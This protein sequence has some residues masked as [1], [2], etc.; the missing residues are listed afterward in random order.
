MLNGK[1]RFM[2]MRIQSEKIAIFLLALLATGIFSYISYA[3]LLNHSRNE[4]HGLLIMTSAFMTAYSDDRGESTVVPATH[5]RRA[6]DYFTKESQESETSSRIT[7]KMPGLPDFE[8]NTV[9]E[10][11]EVRD[12]ISEL[13]LVRDRTFKEETHLSNQRLVDRTIYPSI[14]NSQSC[15]D[16]HNTISDA[17]EWKVGDVMGAFVVESDLTRQTISIAIKSLGVFIFT[18]LILRFI[19][20]R[21]QLQMTQTVLALEAEIIAQKNLQKAERKAKIL[22]SSDALTGLA[23]RTHFRKYAERLLKNEHMIVAFMVDLDY[24]KAINDKHGHQVGDQLLIAISDR[25][26][27]IFQ[28][29]GGL[30]SR[31]GGDEFAAVLPCSNSSSL[32]ADF[33][34][35]VLNELTLPVELDSMQITPSISIG[36]CEGGASFAQLSQYDDILRAADVALY[37]AKENGRNNSVVY[38][39]ELGLIARNAIEIDEAIPKALING[40]FELYF[41]PQVRMAGNHLHGFEALV[42]WRR[43]GEMVM[44]DDFIPIIEKSGRICDVDHF[45]LAQ[46]TKIAARWNRE[47]HNEISVSVNLSPLHFK[48][49]EIVTYVE[50]A[51]VRS[52]LSPHLLTL[53]ITENVVMDSIDQVA[54][55]IRELKSLGVRLSLDDFGTGYSSLS[56]LLS[57][58]VDEVKLDR[59]FL[60]LKENQGVDYGAIDGIC[61]MVRSMGRQLVVEGIETKTTS[62]VI[63]NIGAEYGQGYYFAPPLS[64]ADVDSYIGSFT[65]D[66]PKDIGRAV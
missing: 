10:D 57:L 24:F 52:N 8:I 20:R 46:A 29:A 23:N 48:S 40:E 32:L 63:M 3:S 66:V 9:A 38:T 13:Q 22:A 64:E 31:I 43:N 26:A 35:L 60:M 54:E 39:E 5:R 34:D 47:G 18:L 16:C 61:S 36:L 4:R 27:L 25:L 14:A 6:L 50:D 1:Y 41:Q 37:A 11:P 62:D 45:V 15:V 17:R 30:S 55:I 2:I 53:E 59:S 56:Y 49:H 58:D 33:G 21:E 44:P 28:N 42:R 19:S 7:M 65:Q 51:L 12:V